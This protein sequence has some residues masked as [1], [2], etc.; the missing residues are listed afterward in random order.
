[1]PVKIHGLS[2]M[3]NRANTATVVPGFFSALCVISVIFV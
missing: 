1:M 3:N 2:L